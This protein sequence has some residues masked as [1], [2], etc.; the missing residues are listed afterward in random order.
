MATDKKRRRVEVA[1]AFRVARH[2]GVKRANQILFRALAE[3]LGKSWAGG[4]DAGYELVMEYARL[5]AIRL[6]GP[7]RKAVL[8]V[9][10]PPP[11]NPEL[12]VTSD[13]FLRSYQWRRLR[14]V[15]L[16]K[17]GA[18][19]E[20]CGA[21]PTDGITVLNVDHIKPRRRFPELALDE[22]NLQVLCEPCNHGKGNWDQTDWRQLA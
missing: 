10:L 18:R 3:A 12:D 2:L 1:V 4:K 11:P 16:T 14:M 9:V 20:C 22:N 13:A 15:V 6:S 17:R 7:S 5:H 8:R 19:C 21:T